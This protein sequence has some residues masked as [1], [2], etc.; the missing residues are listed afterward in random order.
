MA[1]KS[2]SRNNPNEG[3]LNLESFGSNDKP[4][5]TTNNYVFNIVGNNGQ[6]FNDIQSTG[7]TNCYLPMDWDTSYSFFPNKY[8]PKT[9]Y[10]Y[11]I[12][13]NYCPSPF[14]KDGF[15]NDIYCSSY[16]ST[17][18]AFSDFNGKENTLI[19]SNKDNNFPN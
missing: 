13:S 5:I 17:I 1:L 4:I 12:D 18:N 7:I 19:L 3:S 6:I 9:Q 11:K 15:K 14:I 16:L 10:M 2:A 8:D